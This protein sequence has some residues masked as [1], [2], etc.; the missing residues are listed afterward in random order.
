[1][2]NTSFFAIIIETKKILLER[3]I[4]NKIS[5]QLIIS[6]LISIFSL[7]LLSPAYPIDNNFIQK[8]KETEVSA[9]TDMNNNRMIDAL[10]KIIELFRT[11]PENDIE[12]ADALLEP[13]H[14][15]SFI[16]N[17]FYSPEYIYKEK[18][19]Q[20]DQYPSDKLLMAVAN[21]SNPTTMR[22]KIL[23]TLI[24]LDGL[25][26]R[27]NNLSI[28][29][30]AEF[31]RVCVLT[32]GGLPTYR[33]RLRS[34]KTFLL[35][36]KEQSI[37]SFFEKYPDS[38][39]TQFVLQDLLSRSIE[40]VASNFNTDDDAADFVQTYLESPERLYLLSTFNE[41]GVS[42]EK[43]EMLPGFTKA[44]D[45]LPSLN[46]FDVN[47]Q[48]I[49]K[50]AEIL[51]DEQDVNARYTLITFLKCSNAMNKECKEIVKTALLSAS[52]KEG[53]TRDVLYAK[54]TLLDLAMKCYWIKEAEESLMD[55]SQLK[56]LPPMPGIK[57]VYIQQKLMIEEGISFFT[58]QGYYETAK[59]VLN[60]Q[61]NKYQ[62]SCFEV[63][64]RNKLI[65]LERVSSKSPFQTNK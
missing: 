38:L 1:L 23:P 28:K 29:F 51:Q 53:L 10:Q 50:W 59:K 20:Q 14:L 35:T 31:M 60:V 30:L 43:L 22:Y 9:Y 2:T 6:I 58:R 42:T 18:L 48:V 27:N 15:Y 41:I 33:Y 25:I 4:V 63:K 24:L 3:K 13:I 39:A 54:F 40:K 34:G 44:K 65:E 56:I 36:I 32:S 19:I 17:E 46:L 5:T 11:V 49:R 45:V 62:G 57:S 16:I 8:I 37:D 7:S 12:S 64:I 61:L 21:L 52:R 47:E 26:N 55:I